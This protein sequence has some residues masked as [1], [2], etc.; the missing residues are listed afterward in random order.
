M[1]TVRTQVGTAW[2]AARRVRF[3]PVGTI[4]A[5]DV[6]KAIEEVE[7][8]AAGSL[9]PLTTP[10]VVTA[11]GN[12][13][14]TSVVVQTNQVAAIV[15]T[16]PLST[17]WASVNSKYGLPLTIF[18]ISGAASSNNVTINCSGG[19]TISGLASLTINTDYG[20]FRLEPKSG[21]GWVVT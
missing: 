4:S 12:V 16:L 2:E 1:V 11:T 19:Q 20:G 15:L 10:T 5:T 21:G 3:E 17:A 13:A 7:S 18:D 14:A 9:Q 6:Q 8:D